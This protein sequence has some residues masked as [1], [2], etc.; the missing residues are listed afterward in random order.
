[1]NTQPLK[2]HTAQG[3]GLHSEQYTLLAPNSA[4]EMI[5][6]IAHRRTVKTVS[7]RNVGPANT[8]SQIQFTIEQYNGDTNRTTALSFAVP[9]NMVELFLEH[10]NT[11]K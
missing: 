8:D 5:L 10:L 11:V 2:E 4:R 7:F 1:M 3:I 9:A 6:K